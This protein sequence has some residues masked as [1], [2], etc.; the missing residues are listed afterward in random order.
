MKHMNKPMVDSSNG[1]VVSNGASGAAA[2]PSQGYIAKP[3]EKVSPSR[4][5]KL[6]ITRVLVVLA[7]VFTV[8]YFW[9][10]A[11]HTMNPAVRV[12]FYSFLAV[13]VLSFIESALFYFVTWN[14]TV[15][16]RPRPLPER[17]VDVLIPTYNE[18]VEL[19]RETVLCAVNIRYPHKTYVL[20]DGNRPAV[21]ELAEEFGCGYITREQREHAKAG[22]L[23]NALQH[24]SGEFLVTLDADHVALPEL[25]EEMIGFFADPQV[26]VVQ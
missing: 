9:W 13:E 20:D 4:Q 3:M 18:P 24:T 2:P 21:R 23:N 1:P 22:N 6:A 10:R 16:A 17:T 15:Y 26:A 19:L 5:F 25:I 12:F 7:A 11:L 8:R 14:P